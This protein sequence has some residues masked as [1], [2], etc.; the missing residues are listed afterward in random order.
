MATRIREV[1]TVE[2][3]CESCG[4][5]FEISKRADRD[6]RRAGRPAVCR[7]CRYCPF[8]VVTDD[9][10]E[11]WRARM[12]PEEALPLAELVFGFRETWVPGEIAIRP[13]VVEAGFTE[14]D[15]RE[16]MSA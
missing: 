7:E 15:F 8:P 10:V 13:I 12:T 14:P 6:R 16:M 3:L 11:W 4:D 1:G 5:G 2:L 9:L